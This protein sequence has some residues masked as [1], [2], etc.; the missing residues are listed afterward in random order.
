[1]SLK[2][3]GL[4]DVLYFINLNQ[5]KG[6]D[7]KNDQFHQF[8][9]AIPFLRRLFT[10][11][12][13]RSTTINGL[14]PLQNDFTTIWGELYFDISSGNL[15]YFIPKKGNSIN[16]TSTLVLSG[17]LPLLNSYMKHTIV[18]FK[19][20]RFSLRRMTGGGQIE[21]QVCQYTDANAYRRDAIAAVFFNK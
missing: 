16:S 9:F 18:A 17:P 7:P 21:E 15:L 11:L 4:G 14:S 3:S 13:R 20:T 1:M 10:S 19:D 2:K 6:D 12:N 8:Q 5:K